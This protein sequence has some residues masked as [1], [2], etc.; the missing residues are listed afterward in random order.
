M[1]E[2]VYFLVM[3]ASV[4]AQGILLTQVAHNFQV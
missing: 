1:M 2:W 4:Q 3:A